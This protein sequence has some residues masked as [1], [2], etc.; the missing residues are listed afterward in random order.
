MTSVS[1]SVR[2]T[3]EEYTQYCAS[4]VHTPLLPTVLGA[5]CLVGG[6][7]L[8]ATGA[9][10]ISG[11]VPL[12]IVAGILAI[13]LFSPLV[14]I[15]WHKSE[16]AKR[17]DN[18]DSLKQAVALTM[19]EDSVTVRTACHEGTLPLSLLTATA[20]TGDAIGLCFGAELEICIPKRALTTE[21]LTFIKQTIHRVKKEQSL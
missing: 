21:E 11:L 16:A 14:L 18:A 4:R 6:V 15:F 19:S 7:A 8:E 1:V 13:F 10:T 9:A 5:V 2:C 12:M 17:Y 3:R 20:E